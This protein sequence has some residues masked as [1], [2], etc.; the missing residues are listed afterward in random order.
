M[1]TSNA[2]KEVYV[3]HNGMSWVSMVGTL[4]GYRLD[5]LHFLTAAGEF[6]SPKCPHQPWSPPS[7]LFTGYW[8]LFP[9][10]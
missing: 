4:T 3:H 2:F 5:D 10:W 9:H 1:D 6:S 7:L 8:G